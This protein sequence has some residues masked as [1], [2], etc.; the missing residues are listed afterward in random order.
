MSTTTS[1]SAPQ[2]PSGGYSWRADRTRAGLTHKNELERVT[3]MARSIGQAAVEILGGTRPATQ[4]ARW[5]T[6]DVVERFEERA[7]MLRL[8]QEQYRDRASLFEIHRAPR[9]RRVRICSPAPECY[10]ASLV[11]EE[12]VRARAVALRIER[13][14][15]QWRVVH[16][17]VG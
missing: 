15:R 16:L 11:I 3:A 13:I 4:L 1:V 2:P 8:V 7:A 17:E 9:V 14:N 6:P 5:T 12:S 10:E